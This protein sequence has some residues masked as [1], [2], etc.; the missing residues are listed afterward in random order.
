MP[1]LKYLDPT[2]GKYVPVT[3]PSLNN[4]IVDAPGAK[5]YNNTT[6]SLSSGDNLMTVNTVI[7]DTHGFWS[8]GT[9]TRLT[10]PDG[11][12]G[13]YRIEAFSGRSIATGIRH[14][15]DIKI[16]GSYMRAA[17]AEWTSGA[18]SEET[19]TQPSVVEYLNVGDYIEVRTWASAAITIG[20][21]TDAS[22]QSTM[23][24]TRQAGIVGPQGEKGDAGD[25]AGTIAHSATTGQTASDHHTKYTDAEAVS[26]VG[27]P[28][29]AQTTGRTANDHHAEA[30]NH[31]GNT[32]YPSQ[33][34][35]PER[36]GRVYQNVTQVT[37]TGS[38]A[39]MNWNLVDWNE[40]SV[41]EAGPPTHL[42]LNRVGL[43]LVQAQV[44]WYADGD[45]SRRLRIYH[46]NTWVRSLNRSS[47][48]GGGTQ[49][50]QV[51]TGI[52]YSG[53]T[54]DYVR[55]L[56]LHNAGNNLGT[57]PGFSETWFSAV[58]LHGN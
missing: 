38:E 17:R 43:W 31:S 23:I 48:V 51:T 20:S 12:A 9:P 53:S 55:V 30:H 1:V 42:R 15:L 26:A 18:T 2:T 14:F 45:G 52:V 22:V 57:V 50:S 32:L 44:T 47:N 54:S 5:V 10:I 11:Q 28:T 16:N 46:N 4:S 40:Q 3:G 37:T 25:L 29:H 6:Q 33:I 27:Y 7:R 35:L 24:I 36:G 49:A 41:V 19:A 39:T 8:S 21:A 56:M 34:Y 58:F 13:L